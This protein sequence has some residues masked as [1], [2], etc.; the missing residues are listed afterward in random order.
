M[1]LGA[2]GE[3]RR[4]GTGN[5]RAIK[6]QDV[7]GE[8]TVVRAGGSQRSDSAVLR[9]LRVY[10]AERRQVARNER[11]RT[12]SRVQMLATNHDGKSDQVCQESWPWYERLDKRKTVR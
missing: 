5:T 2:R 9:G 3:G 12:S 10:C 4:D 11:Q 6:P 8:V 7:T 1:A